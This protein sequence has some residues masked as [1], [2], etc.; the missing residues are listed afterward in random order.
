MDAGHFIESLLVILQHAE[1]YCRMENAQLCYNLSLVL[2]LYWDESHTLFSI[3][4]VFLALLHEAISDLAAYF[5]IK[6]DSTTKLDEFLGC[7][8]MFC[9]LL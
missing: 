4:K 8:K 7:W 3:L 1:P 9:V 5:I 2:V 6:P